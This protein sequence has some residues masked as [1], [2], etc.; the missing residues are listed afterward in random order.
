MKVITRQMYLSKESLTLIERD[1]NAKESYTIF[2]N[3]EDG[4]I[5]IELTLT[6]MEEFIVSE[7]VLETI[8]E[9]L[10]PAL[11]ESELRTKKEQVKAHLRSIG[12]TT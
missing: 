8:I 6:V 12:L 10:L 9:G 3:K 11:G 5:E 1:I 7:D 4:T 2:S